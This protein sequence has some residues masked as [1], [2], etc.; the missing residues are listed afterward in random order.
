MKTTLIISLIII[1][2]FATLFLYGRA[3]LRSI[4]SVA[5]H[6]SIL[7]LTDKNSR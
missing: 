1:G 5:N 7:E 3:R 4:P 2:S 6:N